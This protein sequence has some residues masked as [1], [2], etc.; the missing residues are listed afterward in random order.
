MSIP[1]L[2]SME[3]N[4]KRWN[5]LLL[6]AFWVLFILSIIVECMYL[7]VTPLPMDE[8]VRIYV[9]RPTLMLAFVILLAEGGV[10]YLPRHH[11]YILISASTLIAII[12]T[13]VHSSLQYL[14][15][16]LFFPIMISIFYFQHKKLLF[17]IANTI[18]ALCFVRF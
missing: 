5:R 9:L 14:L 4:Q 2:P 16:F 18:I 6:Q 13:A 11:D 7:L 1:P 17:A 10:R 8:F 12:V 15:F 3:F